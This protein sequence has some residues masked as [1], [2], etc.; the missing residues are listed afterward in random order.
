MSA[1]TEFYDLL[2]ISVSASDAEIKTAFKKH[3]IIHHPDKGG[4]ADHFK[5]IKTAYDVL[6]NPEKKREYD[7]I[8]KNRNIFEDLFKNI[9]TQFTKRKTD[10]IIHR[11]EVSLEDLCTNKIAKFE[12]IRNRICGCSNFTNCTICN[13]RGMVTE[14]R[15]FGPMIQHMQNKC[16]TCNGKG[17][18]YTSCD[19][20]SEGLVVD[21][22]IFEIHLNSNIENGHR[23]LFENEGTQEIGHDSGDLIVDIYYKLH[24]VFVCNGRT[25]IYTHTLSLQEALCGFK[26]DLIHPSGELIQVVSNDIITP[27]SIQQLVGKGMDKESNLEIRYKIVFPTRSELKKLG[28]ALI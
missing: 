13:G 20:C 21:T 28:V 9:F 23:Y 19:N 25:L 7:G 8:G 4:N 12:L 18:I 3:A 22:Q 5:K 15:Q 14:I 10:P 11:Y 26:Y 16:N 17:K 6:S 2:E 24:V 27:D 1:N